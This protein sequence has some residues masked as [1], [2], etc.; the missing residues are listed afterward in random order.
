M[1]D[2]TPITDFSAKDALTTGDPEKV[3]SGFDIDDETAAIATAI[4]SKY[5]SSDLST[6]TQAAALTLNT[7][8]ITPSTLKWAL[9]NGTYDLATGVTKDGND[10]VMSTRT[11]TAG[12]G[13]TGTGT[14][15]SDVTLAVGAGTG[16]AVNADDVALS[17]LGLEALVDPNA[18]RIMF[19]DDSAG[20]LAWLTV[21]NGLD[22]TTTTLSLASSTAGAGLT[23]SA[24]VLAVGAGTGITVNANDIAL[25]DQS[26]STTVCVSLSSGTFN[27]DTSSLTTLNGTSL[28]ATD[29]FNV[30]DASASANKAVRWQDFG[31]PVTNDS[32]TTPMLS[33]DR[34]YANKWYS[35][36]NASAISFVIPSNATVDFPVGTVFYIYQAGAGQVTVSVTTDTLRAP[37]G[38]KTANQYSVVCATKVASTTWVLT[39]DCTT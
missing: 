37:N 36:S 12:A 22:L 2:Y 6:T 15:A 7:V 24:G 13:L 28:A 30:W 31:I 23:H 32:T 10:I 38:T 9:E 20:A 16:I 25:T 3:I 34:T 19:W 21:G 11:I 35:C 1:S 8:L 27:L 26:V 5:D 17:F 18:D 14:L 39:G 4:S 33:A 29:R